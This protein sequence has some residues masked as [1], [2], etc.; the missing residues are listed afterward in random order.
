MGPF[1]AIL[2]FLLIPVATALF[3]FGYLLVVLA[4]KVPPGVWALT[5][6]VVAAA[7]VLRRR[8]GCRGGRRR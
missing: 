8:D 2:I 7:M 5:L 1:A 4:F 3:L 6:S